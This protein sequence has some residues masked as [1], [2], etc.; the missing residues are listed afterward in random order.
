MARAP[1]AGR[2]KTRIARELGVAAA[3]RFARH[4]AAS[5]LQRLAGDARWDTRLAL[6]PDTAP[7]RRL[8]PRGAPIVPQGAGDLGARMQRLIDRAPPGPVVIVGTDVPGIE[9][10]HVAAAFR[11]LGRHD[12]VL[13]PAADGGYWLVGLKRRPRPL[14]PFAGVRWSTAHAF[15]DTLANLVGR[16]V[17]FAATLGDVDTASDLRACSGRPGRRIRC[18]TADCTSA[19]KLLDEG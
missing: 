14:R 6:T 7:C 17:G 4:N 12:A 16:S 18:P 11:L 1:V 5:L 10:R 2:V 15:A 13:G 9:P 19:A 8:M 3:L